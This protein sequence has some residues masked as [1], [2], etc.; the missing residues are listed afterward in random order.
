MK[1]K[2]TPIKF[3]GIKINESYLVALA[4][5]VCFFIFNAIRTKYENDTLKNGKS[6]I[7][8]A[9]IIDVGIR[10]RPGLGLKSR[11]G[12]IKFRYYIYGKEITHW[13]E[14]FK[15]RENIEQYKIG[16]CIELWISLDDENV[17]EWNK[18][19]GTFKCR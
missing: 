2:K 5:L 3:L 12:Y 17:F 13:Q 15:I 9:E 6:A 14:S 10:R 1:G 11:V 8:A 7:V 4:I 18:S 16:D 19:K